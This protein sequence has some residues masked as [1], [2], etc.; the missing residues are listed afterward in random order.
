MIYLNP[1]SRSACPGAT[2]EMTEYNTMS[3]DP[4]D[5]GS[6]TSELAGSGAS[7]TPG[8]EV[9]LRDDGGND[10]SRTSDKLTR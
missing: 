10:A 4:V 5:L 8:T 9:K 6:T 3:A 7:L 2:P 1:E